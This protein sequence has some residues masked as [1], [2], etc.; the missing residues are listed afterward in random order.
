MVQSQ[1]LA[2]HITTNP[3]KLMLTEVF[4]SMNDDATGTTAKNDQTIVL[5]GESWLRLNIDNV[6][7]RKHYASQRMRL[8][9]RLLKSLREKG[10]EDQAHKPMSDFLCTLHF[11]CPRSNR[12]ICSIY[13]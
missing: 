3:S 6:E 2:G 1:V 12:G 8:S 9:A 11:D 10:G 7:K 13:G 4:T 5:L